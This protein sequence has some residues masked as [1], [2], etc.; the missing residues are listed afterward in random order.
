MVEVM[1]NDS[2][3][4][5]VKSFSNKLK[6]TFLKTAPTVVINVRNHEPVKSTNN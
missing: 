6:N 3:P 1:I 5:T 2:K 4:S